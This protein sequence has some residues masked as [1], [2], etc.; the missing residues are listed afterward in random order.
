[1]HVR[2]T[3][4]FRAGTTGGSPVRGQERL[5]S[6]VHL[7]V[8]S[9]CGGF[10]RLSSCLSSSGH[11]SPQCVS[12]SATTGWSSWSASLSRGTTSPRAYSSSIQ[13]HPAT[14]IRVVLQE[15]SP[16]Q[17]GSRESGRSATAASTRA[18]SSQRQYARRR[19]R[20]KVASGQRIMVP[21]LRQLPAHRRIPHA[22][23]AADQFER[24]IKPQPWPVRWSF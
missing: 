5:W 16:S 8:P 22:P 7:N 17:V 14:G 24:P 13:Q 20:I 12:F 23:A 10:H 11:T 2:A 21:S 1:M 15:S 6:Q 19:G 18:Q 4:R 9:Y 3:T